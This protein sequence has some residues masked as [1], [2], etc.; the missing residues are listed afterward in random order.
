MNIE[1]FEKSTLEKKFDV[2]LMNPPFGTKIKGADVLFLKVAA[3]L[4]CNV[5]YSLHK[6][7]T[8]KFIIKKCQSLGYENTKVIAELS[9]FYLFIKLN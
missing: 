3:Q 4:N 2:I 6:T 7:S 1:D 9:I 5:I 8:R